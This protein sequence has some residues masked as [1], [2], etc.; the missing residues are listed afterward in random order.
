MPGSFL[1]QVTPGFQAAAT[2]ALQW[3]SRPS[4][5]RNTTTIVTA[6][7]PSGTQYCAAGSTADISVLIAYASYSLPCYEG[8]YSALLVLEATAE[9]AEVSTLLSQLRTIV[10]KEIRCHRYVMDI[11]ET[12]RK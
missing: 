9:D 10:T 5:D 1:L 8:H 12:R 3:R 11:Y 6:A 2:V 7:G 4:R